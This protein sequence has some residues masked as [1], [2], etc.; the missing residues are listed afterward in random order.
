MNKSLHSRQR[1]LT[2]IEL[3]VT[4][5]IAGIAFAAIVPVF[6]QALKVGQG[7]RAR[8]IAL[9]VAQDRIEKIRELGYEELTSANLNSSSFHF[10]MFGT[11]AT[12]TAGSSTKTYDVTYTV[13]PVKV[14]AT[15]SRVAYKS[16]SVTVEWRGPPYP[17]KKVAL[18]TS[19]Y[20]QSA[21][22]RIIDARIDPANLHATDKTE[23][24][25]TPVR[26]SYFVDEADLVAME[27]KLIGIAPNQRILQGRVEISVSPGQT[28]VVPYSPPSILLGAQ[29]AGTVGRTGN[30]FFVYWSP[31]GGV[32]GVGDGYY[33][34]SA[35]AFSTLGYIG[36]ASTLIGSMK[37]ETGAPPAV[38][39]LTGSA[40]G[41]ALGATD[42]V[43]NLTWTASTATDLNHYLVY[44]V[45]S[46]SGLN[47]VLVAGG[48]NWTATGTPDT[49]L[50]VGATYTYEV[51][52]WDWVNEHSTATYT[53]TVTSA[54]AIAPNA[55]SD[56]RAD[57]SGNSAI[58]SWSISTS[59]NVAG[60]HVY[61]NDGTT[62][63]LINTI[64]TG[65]PMNTSY[66]Q[67]ASVRYY[68]VKAYRLGSVDST[69]ASVFVP[70]YV[71]GIVGGETWVRVLS[72]AA[73]TYNISAKIN[74]V[75]SQYSTVNN[76]SLWY[77]GPSGTTPAVPV[78]TT[79]AAAVQPVAIV[80][81]TAWN[82]QTAGSYEF[83]WNWVKSNGQT[84]AQKKTFSCSGGTAP[85]TTNQ[86]AIP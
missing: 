24:V 3:L 74:S 34:F 22:P 43:A 52:A 1:G 47:R 9:S 15:D 19:V 35:R 67:G 29:P 72:T 64:P 51:E 57:L 31:S 36:E 61:V 85:N 30:E 65:S 25:R 73:A 17:H 39:N 33:S 18:A 68:T 21:G 77:L 84:S 41:S 86:V 2:L 37:V 46:P 76:V 42:G 45:D 70:G 26:V 69:A 20:R 4:I 80:T 6:V 5:I 44:R 81:T 58:L 83:R 10:G 16:V 63:T 11:T 50:T 59:S 54:S 28:Y 40:V 56:L 75:P 49:R 79:Q 55:P 23:I 12:D 27:P 48:P 71:T 66:N 53:L 7:D 82:G 60:Y 32:S 14:S 62:T 8:A 78:G 13:S 38:T